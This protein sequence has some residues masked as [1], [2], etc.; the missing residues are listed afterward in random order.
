MSAAWITCYYFVQPSWVSL[1]V[2]CCEIVILSSE[3]IVVLLSLL[4]LQTISQNAGCGF[5]FRLFGLVFEGGFLEFIIDIVYYQGDTSNPQSL[6][7][8]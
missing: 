3:V 7:S 2:N 8:S 1:F 6:M 4:G 5:C